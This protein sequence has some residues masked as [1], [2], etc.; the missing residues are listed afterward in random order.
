M[1]PSCQVGDRVTSRDTPGLNLLSERHGAMILNW[2]PCRNLPVS[3]Y[4][5]RY[6]LKHNGLCVIA[7]SGR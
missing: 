2:G 3:A 7:L 1:R 6:T 4:M 5:A